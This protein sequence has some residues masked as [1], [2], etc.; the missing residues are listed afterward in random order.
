MCKKL[1]G[2]DQETAKWSTIVGNEW[3]QVLTSVLTWEESVEML[4][5]MAD[6]RMERYEKAGQGPPGVM[7][8]DRDC[9]RLLGP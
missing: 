5:L 4:Q 9:C 7:Y 8:V 6:G 2:S 1:A 3:S